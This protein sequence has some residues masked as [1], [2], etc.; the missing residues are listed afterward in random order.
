MSLAIGFFGLSPHYNSWGLV[1]VKQKWAIWET[2]WRRPQ[3]HPL[4]VVVTGGCFAA[5]AAAESFSFSQQRTNVVLLQELPHSNQCAAV[6]A[7][8]IYGTVSCIFRLLMMDLREF[9]ASRTRKWR[10]WSHGELCLT[11]TRWNGFNRYYLLLRRGSVDSLCSTVAPLVIVTMVRAT[12]AAQVQ[13]AH[14]PRLAQP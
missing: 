3:Q 13:K 12:C 5:A 9:Q 7:A 2:L 1:T 10:L 4:L 11:T 14:E 8:A 6:S